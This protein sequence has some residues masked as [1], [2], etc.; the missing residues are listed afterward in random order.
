VMLV[1]PKT[2]EIR[3]TRY[4]TELAPNAPQ[5]V[6]TYE[7][8]RDVSGI[9]VAFRA[10]VE[11]DGVVIDRVITSARMNAALPASAFVRKAA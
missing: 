10:H 3:G 1:D 6:E 2:F 9:R 5:A 7:D 8:Y 4:P 11:R